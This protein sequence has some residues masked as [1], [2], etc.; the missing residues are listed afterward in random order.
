MAGVVT[1]AAALLLRAA[2]RGGRWTHDAGPALPG[3]G[4]P[5]RRKLDAFTHVADGAM[6]M[7]ARPQGGSTGVVSVG[8]K[9]LA[10]HGVFTSAAYHIYKN[11]IDTI[12]PARVCFG[13]K[14]VQIT[15]FK[16][17]NGCVC[18]CFACATCETF[19]SF[20][21]SRALHTLEYRV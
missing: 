16:K 1:A 15:F 10:E 18:T 7:R 9:S 17:S 5:P 3:P 12:D 14:L 4:L 19:C 6:R 2:G 8:E 13:L 20:E 11:N 21:T